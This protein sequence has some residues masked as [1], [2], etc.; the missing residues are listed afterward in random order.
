MVIDVETGHAPSLHRVI[1]SIQSIEGFE[2]QYQHSSMRKI[3]FQNKYKINS[4]RLRTWN[5]SST[6]YYFITICVK[7]R[8][9]ILG[10]IEQRTFKNSWI[11]EVVQKC[12]YD[13]PHH[14][15]DV[16]LDAFCVMPNHIHGIIIINSGRDGACPV[17]TSL[18]GC[19]VGSMNYPAAS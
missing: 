9:C 10:K 17:Y 7:K 11:G 16:S 13:I 3:Y 8:E 18:L 6:G 14:F 19:I 15:E 4:T 2:T 5:Y 1:C 12:W